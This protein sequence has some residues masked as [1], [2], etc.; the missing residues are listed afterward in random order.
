MSRSAVF[1]Q[2]RMASTRLPGKALLPLADKTVISH[3]MD[4]LSSLPVHVHA[5]LTDDDSANALRPVV[6]ASGYELYCGDPNDVLWRFCSAA[7]HFS[8]DTIVR[9]TGDNPLVSA[10]IA[11]EALQLQAVTAADYAG[12][13]D[14]PYG[15][16]VEVVRA[17]ALRDVLQRFRDP[18]YREHVTPGVYQNPDR[19]AVITRPAAASVRFPSMRV[20]LDT[21]QDY[22][23]LADLFEVLY[24]G[25]P[26][27][28]PEL[29]TY[30]H[31][32]HRTSA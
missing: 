11:R 25:E 17:H 30:G 31:R 23:Y 21:L 9:A 1:L 14:T 12:I 3:A 24:R 32:Q 15:T 19:Y 26:I 22:H 27:E 10:A 20:T 13:T 29:V 16:G 7:E 8:I 18:Y 28:L 5:V 4:A 6:E 2:V